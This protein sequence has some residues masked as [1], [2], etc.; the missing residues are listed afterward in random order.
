MS[1]RD[2][3]PSASLFLFLGSLAAAAPAVL[4]ADHAERMA[5][6]LK[7]FEGGVRTLL[8]NRCLHCHGGEETESKFDLSTREGL[9]AG[10][11]SGK[12]AVVP[13]SAEESRLLHQVALKE[14]PYMPKEGAKLK[15]AEIALVREW[16]E[17][18]APYDAPLV[19]PHA[20]EIPW[21]ER[22]IADEARDYW[23]FKP[24]ADVA[25]PDIDDPWARTPVDRFVLAKQREH[26]LR[27]N[28]EAE[29]WKLIRRVTFDL[30]GLPPTPEEIDT[31]LADTSPDAFGKVVDR[32]LASPRFGE[33][34]ARHWLDVARFGESEGG[35]HDYDR[36]FAYHYR[37]F[38]IRALNEDMPFDR[39]VRWQLAGDEFAPD[40]PQALMATGF[41]TAG[42][43]PTQLTEVEFE[44]ARYDQLDDMASTTTSA[45]L[46]LTVGCARCHDHKF[47]PIPQRDYYRFT[48]AFSKTIRSEIDLDVRSPEERE[49]ERLKNAPL[50]AAARGKLEAFERDTLPGAFSDYVRDAKADP[51]IWRT[52]AFTKTETENGTRLETQP[53]GSLAAKGH[54]PNTE[55]YTL[56]TR[57]AGIA[58]AI[59]VEAL[60]D[61]TLPS[62]GPGL[63]GNG[64]F[65]LSDLRVTTP[66][67]A[68]A[69]VAPRVTHEQDQ[70]TLSA[71]ASLD[72]DRDGSGWAV[73]LGGIGKDN[74]AAFI[75]EKPVTDTALT[76][77]LRFHHSNPKHLLG[78]F[79]IS[80]TD[81]D[82]M[83]AP[84]TGETSPIPDAV[85]S[86]LAALRAGRKIDEAKTVAARSWFASTL[87]AWQE[88]RKS[89]DDATAADAPRMVKVQVGSE[90]L[91]KVKHH[92]DDRGYPHF[93][94]DTY[95]LKRGDPAQKEGVA[96]PGFIQVLERKGT[97]DAHWKTS[98]PDGWRTSFQR[99][100]LA[101]WMTDTE[102][103]AGHLVARVIVNRL[104][105]QYMGRGIVATPNDF[106]KQ[107]LP[108]SDPEL[109]DW[110]A[111]ELIANGWQLKPIHRLLV[112][113]AVY[114][115]NVDSDPDRV[116][117][118][119]E[120][121]FA[122]RQP[123]R[124]LEAEAIRDAMLSVSNQLDPT[125][126]GPGTSD[127]AMKRRSIYFF[128]KRS[129][130][131]AALQLFDFPE[132]LVSQGGRPETTVAPQALLFMNNA[133]VREH[134]RAFAAR[135]DAG[136][137]NTAIGQAYRMALG[138]P[139]RAEEVAANTA[140]LIEQTASYQAEN[141]PSPA[142]DALTD[143]CQALF[144]QNQF[145]YLE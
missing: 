110:L 17:A 89:L 14:K 46:A 136:N 9:L 103:G 124:R 133:Q 33:R 71:A 97:S 81:N 31:F 70:G 50:V 66:E 29:R 15:P 144:C 105:A 73:D 5:R 143:F 38:V 98:P 129:G 109:L 131:P 134:A 60:A 119:P 51:Q 20:D 41:L 112:T 138:R 140:F 88:L 24:L 49:S 92:A 30:T 57:V 11:E 48:A 52:L 35:E 78:H 121:A 94:P 106:G 90:G 21:T 139:P 113:S 47:D 68:V 82:P 40:N 123:V 22:V 63:A 102:S 137:V 117:L 99:R 64:N 10:G 32:L 145:V 69:L 115:Q 13:F 122:W 8:A 44:P 4:P 75:L 76:L 86:T 95:F 2:C 141:S 85:S 114:R 130:I 116:A 101:N 107:A 6:G 127:E 142:A 28:P 111:R 87:P 18:G 61:A 3:L 125:M 7:I 100:S 19:D 34:W 39:F 83:T 79:R 80:I 59:R 67:G 36:N 65:C 91:P 1:F 62:G 56:T 77:T 27:P 104:W 43:F 26:G 128:L 84:L 132:P 53:D 96:E 37:D 55:T 45:F 23:A 42:T 72:D 74:A 58:R 118:D 25:V 120:N 16:I 108:P 54:I 12:T 126:Y 93:Y 135:L